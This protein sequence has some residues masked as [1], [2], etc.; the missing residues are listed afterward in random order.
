MTKKGITQTEADA[1][2]S[3]LSALDASQLRHAIRDTHDA[4]AVMQAADGA[5]DAV[6]DLLSTAAHWSKDP[7]AVEAVDRRINRPVVEV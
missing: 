2:L 3:A 5:K 6:F 7:I 1:L 4:G